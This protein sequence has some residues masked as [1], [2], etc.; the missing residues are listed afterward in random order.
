MDLKIHPIALPLRHP[1]TI[2]RGTTEVYEAAIVE[3]SQ[4]GVSGYGELVPAACYGQHVDEAISKIE[5]LRSE[6]VGTEVK[7][8]AVLWEKWCALFPSMPSVVNALDCAC[9]DLWGK[10]RSQPIWRYWNL[11]L[12]RTPASSITIGIDTLDR[13]V[14]KLLEVADWPVIKI[15]LGTEDDLA[16]VRELRRHTKAR[17]RVD[18][19][20]AWKPAE[21]IENAK[22][23]AELDVEFIEQPL[24]AEDWE[25]MREVVRQSELPI[26]ADESCVVEADIDRCV[27]YFHGVNIKLVKCGGPTAARRMLLRARHLQLSTMI[28]C[29][30]ETSVG[31]SAAAN[32]APLA[33]YLDLDGA[34][35]LAQ[36]W[37]DG[38]VLDHGRLE[39]PPRGGF[40]ILPR[41]QIAEASAVDS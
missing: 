41:E 38:V 12:D 7:H 13:M 15:K 11:P 32:L 16:I 1:F 9:Y 6:I 24:P 3:L 34:V 22:A 5:S 17:F 35:L 20:E 39:F 4:D 26:I 31:I 27:S 18:A 2:S 28:G 37:A 36:D 25:G 30:T 21:T 10:L 23:M 33:D 19:N 40:G 29:M 8:P 14:E